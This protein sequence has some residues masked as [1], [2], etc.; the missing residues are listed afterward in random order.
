MPENL[1][2]LVNTVGELEPN[3]DSITALVQSVKDALKDEEYGAGVLEAAAA[4][5][6][7]RPPRMDEYL[8]EVGDSYGGGSPWLPDLR[9][10]AASLGSSWVPTRNH[11]LLGVDLSG[12]WRASLDENDRT[13]IRQFGPY[14]NLVMGLSS[15]PRATAEGVYDPFHSRIVFV[16]RTLL[17]ASCTGYA[18][19]HKHWLLDGELQTFGF[20]G[21]PT[22]ELLVLMKIG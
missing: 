22:G 9:S 2:K 17:G 8:P 19:L 5:P 3:A 15:E 10:L 12:I 7:I 18:Q 16:G 4:S 6:W 1:L 11:D 13:Y 20:F 14:L 21:D